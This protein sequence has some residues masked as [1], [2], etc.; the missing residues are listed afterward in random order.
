MNYAR[1]LPEVFTDL[2]RQLNK[3]NVGEREHDQQQ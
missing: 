1:S 2:I 3:Q